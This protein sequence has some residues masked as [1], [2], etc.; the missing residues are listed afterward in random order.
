MRAQRRSTCSRDSPIR[1]FLAPRRRRSL[2]VSPRIGIDYAGDAKDWPLRFFDKE[3]D[4][5]SK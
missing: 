2:G 5:V 4:S 1:I 3:S